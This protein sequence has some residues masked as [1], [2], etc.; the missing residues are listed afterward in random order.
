[1]GRLADAS[2]ALE[3]AVEIS[4]GPAMVGVLQAATVVALGRVAIHTGDAL[5]LKR[6]TAIMREVRG[7]DAPGVRRHAAW[8]LA[9]QASATGDLAELRRQL[10]VLGEQERLT[11]LPLFPRT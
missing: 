8:L 10:R 4:D 2:A 1:M 6:C 3:A 9:H 11:F 5:Q 7:T